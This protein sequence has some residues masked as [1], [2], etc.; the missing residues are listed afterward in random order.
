MKKLL[1]LLFSIL[2]S[3]NSYGE[4]EELGKNVNG[5]IFYIDEDTIKEHNGYVYWWVLVDRLK[6]SKS[7]TMSGK[8]YTQGDCGVNGKIIQKIVEQQYTENCGTT[9][10]GEYLCNGYF[11]NGEYFS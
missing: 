4:W 2:I 6:P 1:I 3:F 9:V 7:G 5:D 8:T 11:C 10:D